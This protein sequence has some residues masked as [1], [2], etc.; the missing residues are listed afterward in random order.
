MNEPQTFK[1]C[2]LLITPVPQSSHEKCSFTTEVL[3][4]GAKAAPRHPVQLRT[5]M[6]Q[7]LL[8][9]NVQMCSKGSL[10]NSVH[11]K[12]KNLPVCAGWKSSAGAVYLRVSDDPPSSVPLEARVVTHTCQLCPR[13]IFIEVRG[14]GTMTRLST[15]PVVIKTHAIFIYFTLYF[16]ILLL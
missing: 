4:E 13:S 14:I 12:K 1:I 6:A 9:K 11:L 10:L 7:G 16:D 3:C 8:L 2:L 15:F 5:A